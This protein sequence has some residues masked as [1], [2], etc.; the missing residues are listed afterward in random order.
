MEVILKKDVENLGYANDIV[1]VK[2]GYANNYLL[3]RGLATVAN[4]IGEEGVGREP[5]NSV[6]IKT[7]R[8]LPTH[9]RSQ[10]R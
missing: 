5:E 3:P 4:R 8:Y 9:R 6:P 1:S 2:P 10:R 7:L